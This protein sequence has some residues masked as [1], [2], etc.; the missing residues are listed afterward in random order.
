MMWNTLK[1]EQRF[2]MSWTRTVLIGVLVGVVLGC[3]SYVVLCRIGSEMLLERTYEAQTLPLQPGCG[4]EP[5]TVCDILDSYGVQAWAGLQESFDN[6]SLKVTGLRVTTDST[7]QPFGDSEEDE[8]TAVMVAQ[9]VDVSKP[10]VTM[11]GLLLQG[12]K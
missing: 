1:K 7:M 10:M 2:V 5:A 3:A 9:P 8:L 11:H 6:G 12:S 4:L